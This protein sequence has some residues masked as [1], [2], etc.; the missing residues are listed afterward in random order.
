MRTNELVLFLQ[1]LDQRSAA[2]FCDFVHAD[3]H[4]RRTDVRQLIRLL[5][6]Y[7]PDF[8]DAPLEKEDLARVL[9]WIG[10]SDEKMGEKCQQMVP[11]V[12]TGIHTKQVTRPGFS[13]IASRKSR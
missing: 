4:N 2:S 12:I 7:H 1:S 11:Q 9:G 5:T 13:D 10:A 6:D 3:L 8:S